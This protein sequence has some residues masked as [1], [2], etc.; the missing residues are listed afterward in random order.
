M[1]SARITHEQNDPNSATIPHYSF[2]KAVFHIE[3]LSMTPFE[4]N[5]IITDYTTALWIVIPPPSS[6]VYSGMK[7]NVVSV[8]IFFNGV[9]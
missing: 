5:T 7:D 8:V 9:D 6:N 4:K 2:L 1:S 3:T